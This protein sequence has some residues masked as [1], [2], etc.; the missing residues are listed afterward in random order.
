MKTNEFIVKYSEELW[1]ISCL[2]VALLVIV[3]FDR[4][5]NALA[6]FFSNNI[7]KIL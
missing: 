5:Y 3:L 2:L 1:E 6:N 7:L 4:N